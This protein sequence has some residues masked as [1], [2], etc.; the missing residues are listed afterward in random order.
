MSCTARGY[1]YHGDIADVEAEA[2]ATLLDH[3]QDLGSTSNGSSSRSGYISANRIGFPLVGGFVNGEIGPGRGGASRVGTHG[4]STVLGILGNDR[5]RTAALPIYE[6]SP[7]AA[8][9]SAE[10]DR[11]FEFNFDPK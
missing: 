6:A 11:N 2:H 9:G 8:A 4:Y 3:R 1:S 5:S 7:Q 10:D